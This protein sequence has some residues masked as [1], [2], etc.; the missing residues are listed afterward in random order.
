[1]TFRS[2]SV[3]V[4]AVTE[5]LS[6]NETVETIIQSCSRQ[7]LKEV[8]ICPA[9]FASPLCLQAAREL[10]RQ[11]ADIPVRML[12][13][14]GSFE[15][16]IKEMFRSAAGSHFF[17]QPSDLEEDP[18]MV[19][20]FLD[21]VKKHPAAVI[22]GSR[23]LIKEHA[24]E[25]SKAK[26]LVLWVLRFFL[27][28]FYRRRLTD[29]TFFYRVIPVQYLQNLVLEQKSYSVL[30]E[31]FLKIVRSGVEIIEIPVAFR[32]RSDGKSRVRF[33]RDGL[34]YIWVFFRVRFSDTG[35]FYAQGS[36]PVE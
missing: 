10:C 6:L 25:Y 32:K 17:I 28:L 27:R 36:K 18:H 3:F 22:S 15:D 16:L 2:L 19:L 4:P 33:F 26:R 12:M 30:Y 13:Q 14:E 1:M 35:K 21:E 20:A 34:R 23:F 9:D 29:T 11:H 7:D 24:G 31:A 5:T 8:V